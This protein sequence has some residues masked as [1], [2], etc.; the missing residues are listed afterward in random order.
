M[1]I[2]NIKDFMIKK[3]LK[4]GTMNESELQRDCNYKIYPRD[5]MI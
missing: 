1:K 4:T 5:L 2:L 3:I